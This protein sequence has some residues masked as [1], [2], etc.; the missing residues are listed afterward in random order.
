MVQGGVIMKILRKVIKTFFECGGDL[1]LMMAGISLMAQYCDHQKC[2]WLW[3][4]GIVLI[5][6]GR[7]FAM[8]QGRIEGIRMEK[9]NR[10]KYLWETTFDCPFDCR[11]WPERKENKNA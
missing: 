1:T 2:W 5:F 10:P 7:F 6:T 11:C 4:V 8:R 9:R 3:I